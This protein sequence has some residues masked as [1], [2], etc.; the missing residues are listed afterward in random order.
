MKNLTIKWL[1]LLCFLS[2]IQHQA[3]AQWD[4][5]GNNLLQAGILGSNTNFEV[6]FR[7]DGENRMKLNQSVSY[8]INGFNVNRDGFVW[9]GPDAP[10][11]GGSYYNNKGAF[12]LLHLNGTTTL[13]AIELGYRPWM[14][15]GITF[16][17]NSDM[18]YVGR[19]STDEALD[20][21]DAVIS[22]SDD[23]ASPPWS[24]PD[25]MLFLFT[26]GNAGGISNPDGDLTGTGINGRE[27]MRMT[28][29]GNIGVGPRFNN[30]HQPKS[31]LHQHQENFSD[32]WYQVTN[33]AMTAPGSQTEPTAINATN[34]L[35]VGINGDENQQI[36]G[37]ALIYNQENRHLLL[38]TGQN[39]DASDIGN[40]NTLERVRVTSIAAPTNTP[41]GGYGEYNP[42]GLPANLTRVAISHNPGTAVTRPL[43][44]LHLGHN[45]GTAGA[46]TSTHGWRSWMDIGMF[47]TNGTDNLYVGLKEEEGE[48]FDAVINWGDDQDTT[49]QDNLRFIFTST[50]GGSGDAES[51]SLHGKEVGRFA[52]TGEFGIGNFYT[53][54]LDEQPTEKLDVDG[55][56]R[57]RQMPANAPT[58]LITGVEQDEDPVDGDYVLN[59]L[60]FPND[61]GVVLA[62]DGTWIETTGEDCDWEIIENGGIDDVITGHG[63]E[64]YPAGHVGVGVTVPQA[65][66]DV[67]HG[68]D[69]A[70]PKNTAIKAWWDDDPESENPFIDAY[71]IL[72]SVRRNNNFNGIGVLGQAAY[73]RANYGGVF[74]AVANSLGNGSTAANIG[75]QGSAI[76]NPDSG[77]GTS[78]G[79]DFS[80]NAGNSNPSQ[81]VFGVRA[82]AIGG[83]NAFGVYGRAFGASN[84]NWAGYFDGDTY[85]TAGVWTSSDETLKHNVQPL[86]SAMD[87]IQQIEPKE[88]S[89]LTEQFSQM[90]LPAGQQ[91]G[92]IAQ[93]LEEVLPNLVKSTTHPAQ[94]DTLGNEISEAVEFKSV[95]YTGL[96]PYLIAGIKEQQS[97]IQT[98]DDE[99]AGLHEALAN[100]NELI[101]QMM[102]QMEM[103]QQQINGCCN[104]DALPKNFG[105]GDDAVPSAQPFGQNELYQNVPNPFRGQTT[106][107]YTLEQGGRAMLNIHDSNGREITQLENAEQ[108]AGTYSYVWDAT[109]LPAGTYH[110]SLIVDGE[111]LVKRAIK[112]QD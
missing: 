78:A 31:T 84:E 53:N 26:K 7:T 73:G 110:Y 89:F 70:N 95:N 46:P 35:R 9:L 42:A 6:L 27:V 63:N 56:A 71:G 22:W 17:E 94:Y 40:G 67:F 62:G 96:I 80:A 2:M 72:S 54:G 44:L 34:G 13:A 36:N 45:I 108:V 55:T 1:G 20:Q 77:I 5:N 100:Q 28:A 58:V 60:E 75:V 10:V 59:Y 15:T 68:G 57:L 21:T 39:T 79:G 8:D 86:E 112:L 61:D 111:L 106:I 104:G 90:N 29:S 66:L 18:M 81:S 74:R 99:I 41:T 102:D 76:G 85:C 97:Q 37:N 109:G 88:Y 69:Q 93:E 105:S 49:A 92:V 64:C 3:R 43:S 4:V 23:E 65:K 38:S 24:G 101:M 87:I 19:K 14:K 83:Y 16:T 25:N 91:Q 98:Q 82:R 51:Q 33:Q 48:K 47:T 30:D 12:S 32:S 52:P 103:L 107:R 11:S 50:A